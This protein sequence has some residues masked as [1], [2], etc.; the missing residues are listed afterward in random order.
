MGGGTLRTNTPPAKTLT[1]LITDYCFKSLRITRNIYFLAIEIAQDVTH[2][3][4]TII[5]M[6]VFNTHNAA[7]TCQ[8]GC[9]P[10]DILSVHSAV[11]A[12]PK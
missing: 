5:T 4:A 9:R 6:N 2:I 10:S 12:Y 3:F 11:P 7:Y 8:P 1:I